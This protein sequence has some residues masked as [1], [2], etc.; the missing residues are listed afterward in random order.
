MN[1]EATFRVLC[2]SL[3]FI[4]VSICIV[5]VLILEVETEK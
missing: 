2:V 4:H 3:I 1:M 5:S